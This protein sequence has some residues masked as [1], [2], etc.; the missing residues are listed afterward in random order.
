MVWAYPILN[1]PVR[2]PIFANGQQTL[3]FLLLS[4]IWLC[5]MLRTHPRSTYAHDAKWGMFAFWL[6]AAAQQVAGICFD[7]RAI[8]YSFSVFQFGWG[9]QCVALGWTLHLLQMRMMAIRSSAD[10]GTCCSTFGSNTWILVMCCSWHIRHT[11]DLDLE[12]TWPV[13]LVSLIVLCTVWVAYTTLTCKI[14]VGNL[15]LLLREAKRVRGPPRKQAIWAAQVLGMEML[16]CAILG[17]TMCCYGVTSAMCLLAEFGPET[18]EKYLLVQQ[19]T[20]VVQ[21]IIHIDWVVNSL[22]LGLLSG[23]LWQGR[24]PGGD[25]ESENTLTRELISM[26]NLL[27][28]TETS[29]LS[30]IAL[31]FW[32]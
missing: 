31:H 2:N 26:S 1:S 9:V 6:A 24:P 5:S 25:L 20:F 23:I 3:S 30:G 28:P 19:R 16:I 32:G 13:I 8:A 4:L 14:L 17:L 29:Q 15:Q 11:C 21:L 27:T 7:L 12:K 22:G 10:G 18:E